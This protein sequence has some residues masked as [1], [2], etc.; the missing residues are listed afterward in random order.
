MPMIVSVALF[1][2]N[3]SV[4]GGVGN[5]ATLIAGRTIQG[6]GAGGI[7]ILVEHIGALQNKCN[8]LLGS[9]E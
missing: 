9:D 8:N 3:S 7:N 4:A 5:V 6:V 2:I 1:A